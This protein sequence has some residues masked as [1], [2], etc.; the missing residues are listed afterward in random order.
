MQLAEMI[1][2]PPRENGSACVP[3]EDSVVPSHLLN[4][5]NS[6]GYVSASYARTEIL[7]SDGAEKQADLNLCLL[8]ML[9]STLVQSLRCYHRAYM[10]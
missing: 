4:I 8:H 7:L 9:E 3:G 1:G 2:V 10:A 5:V 6:K